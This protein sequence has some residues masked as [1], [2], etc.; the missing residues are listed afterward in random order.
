MLLIAPGSDLP[1]TAES[2]GC[3]HWSDPVM[4]DAD[5]QTSKT[6]PPYARDLQEERVDQLKLNELVE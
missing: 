5:P 3:V 1:A 4:A 6:S 2:I